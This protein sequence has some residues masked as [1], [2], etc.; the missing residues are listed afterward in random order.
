MHPQKNI[1]KYYLILFLLFLTLFLISQKKS[2]AYFEDMFENSS[3]D[4]VSEENVGDVS[5]SSS[6][7]PASLSGI[8]YAEGEFLDGDLLKIS[9]FAQDISAPVLGTAF[10]F[11]YNTENLDFLKYE[12][13]DFLE[14]GGD[15]FYLVKNFKDE[16]EI[17]FGQTLRGNDSFP[18]GSGKIVDF[19]Y[20]VISEENLTFEFK[21]GVISTID[22]VRQDLSN[23]E[24]K[25]F[26]L[27]TEEKNIFDYSNENI[28]TA[29]TEFSWGL[30][31][32][33]L[34]LVSFFGFSTLI[35]K[36]F[37]KFKKYQ[38]QT[39]FSSNL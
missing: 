3:E 15:P 23:I 4:I 17:V 32:V 18:V 28:P 8:I 37:K 25:N 14:Q 27:S 1:R 16:R 6:E 7:D 36:L 12:P 10:H 2:D 39:R 13:G 5:E 26:D 21:N 29:S 19:Y 9:I 34:G 22:T 24:W 35:F 31:E 30:K 20:Q 11:S 38:N 33:L